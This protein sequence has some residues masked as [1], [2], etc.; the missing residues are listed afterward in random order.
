MYVQFKS[1]DK[2]TPENNFYVQ[3]FTVTTVWNT[4]ETGD[5]NC[6]V[7]N[8]EPIMLFYVLTDGANAFNVVSLLGLFIKDPKNFLTVSCVK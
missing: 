6:L 4:G 2:L 1:G 3:R 7:Y 8:M 5:I